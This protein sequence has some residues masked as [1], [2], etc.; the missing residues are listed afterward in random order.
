MPHLLPN[1]FLLTKAYKVLQ[2]V[3]WRGCEYELFSKFPSRFSDCDVDGRAKERDDLQNY[4]KRR[5][6]DDLQYALNVRV[7]PFRVSMI[8]KGNQRLMKTK[9]LPSIVVYLPYPSPNSS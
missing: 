3:R 2:T 7:S 9:V 1:V 6:G 4:C 8:H 5:F